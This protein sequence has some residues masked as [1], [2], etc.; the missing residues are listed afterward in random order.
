MTRNWQRQTAV[1]NTYTAGGIVT[2]S[3]A[4]IVYEAVCSEFLPCIFIE[5]VISKCPSRAAMCNNGSVEGFSM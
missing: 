2:Q 1:E 5:S 3:I 4:E